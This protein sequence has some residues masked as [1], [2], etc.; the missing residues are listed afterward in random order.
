MVKASLRSSSNFFT[1]RQNTILSAATVIM[2]MIAAS[3]ILGLVRNRVLAHFFS[4]DSL[5]IY[6]AA[7][8][9]PEVSFEVLVFGALSSAFIPTFTTYLSRKEGKEAWH[10]AS[11]ALNIA[12]VIF[13]LLS[14]VIFAFAHPIYRI[15]AAGFN[16]DQLEQIVALARLLLLAQGF[17]VLSYFLTGVLESLQRFLVPAIAPLLYNFG[18]ILGTIF[19]SGRLGL[20]A[21]TLGAL[22]GAFMHF[23]IQLP[24]AFHLGFRF[25]KTFDFHHPGVR[26]IGKLAAPRIIELSF[27]E[28]G[29]SVE[30]FLASLISTA[31][32]TYFTFANSLQLL[33]VG[34]FGIS[35]AKASLPTLSYQATE[36]KMNRFK[37]TFLASFNEILFLVVPCAIFLAVLRIPVVRLAFGATR[38][39]WS[40]TVQTGYTVSAFCLGIFS[41]ALVYLLNRA[42]Y[43]L[44]DTATPVKISVSTILFNIL[45]SFLFIL[46]FHW[47]IWG[48]A[49]SF[50]FSSGVQL[51]ALLYFLDRRVKGFEK[52]KLVLPFVKI[53]FSSLFSGGAMF[54]FLKILDQAAWD[55]KL[56]FLGRWGLVLPTT[57][58]RFVLDTRYTFNLILLTGLVALIGGILYLVFVFL[59]KVEELRVLAR[60][61]KKFKRA[62]PLIP[63]EP[64]LEETV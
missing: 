44:H 1:R 28:L 61:V 12:L 24:L 48:L 2:V 18:I 45:L 54:F 58:D 50:S 5:S 17:F 21:P 20:Y 31:A 42:F 56:S 39:T 53:L 46:I 59:L 30:L 14:M 35:I 36:K 62:K 23:A 43:A 55:K 22:V 4:V 47:P 63:P 60:L 11:A 38:F 19:F 41:Q 15:I 3:R 57:F 25:Q 40:S 52:K 6:F 9:L 34:L 27:L 32:Y 33:P 29:K 10:V 51:V 49:L 8:R 16:P 7:F 13:L 37:D 26:E 64:P